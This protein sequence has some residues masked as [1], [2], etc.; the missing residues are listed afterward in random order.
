VKDKNGGDITG[1]IKV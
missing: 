1:P